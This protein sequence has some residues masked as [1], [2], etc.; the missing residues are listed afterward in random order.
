MISKLVRGIFNL[1]ATNLVAKF[2]ANPKLKKSLQTYIDET[3]EFK[4]ELK[5]QG[6]GNTEDLKKALA[7]DPDLP[8]WKNF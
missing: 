4:K 3:N 6:Y 8:D 2:Y 5:R 1:K 7:N